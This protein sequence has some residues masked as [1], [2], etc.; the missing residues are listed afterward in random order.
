MH[1]RKLGRSD[2]EVPVVAMGCWAIVGDATWGEQDEQ[3]ALAAIDAA[4][5][6]GV[7]FYDTAEGYGGGYSEE[8]LGR[9]LESRRDEVIIATKASAGHHDPAGLKQACEDSLTRLRTDYIDLYQLHWPS[10]EVPF[11]DTWAAMEGL[12]QEGKV[13]VGGVSNFGPLDLGDL[14]A[15]GHPDVN[16]LSYSLLFRAIEYEIRPLCEREE[17]GILCYSPMAQGLLTGKFASADEVPEGR[18]RTRVFSAERAEVR[19]GEEGAEE[20]AFAAIAEVRAIAEE[21]GEPMADLAL[22][23][24]LRQPA[25]ACV[26]A[27]MRNVDQARANASAADLALPDEVVARL[28]AVTDALKDKLGPNPDMWQGES[29]IR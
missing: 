22:A 14:L 24:L 10:R 18:A 17:V 16:Q 8:L 1:T 13:R 26:L 20:E 4:F 12:I 23:W 27:G 19:H 2:L 7:N 21:V 5:D 6:A 9:V 25:V 29:R 11:E 28:G 15:A 3:D